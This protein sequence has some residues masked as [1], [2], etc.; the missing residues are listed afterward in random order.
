MVALERQG[1][2][3]LSKR[4]SAPS[5]APSADDDGFE[6]LARVV[7]VTLA[8]AAALHADLAL[9]VLALTLLPTRACVVLVRPCLR[10]LLTL[11]RVRAC[12]CA[13]AHLVLRAG[14][15]RDENEEVVDAGDPNPNP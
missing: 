2:L 15:P 12:A 9:Q 8:V 13:Q 5:D 10:K 6:A 14:E 3:A 11:T 4:S 7:I 1:A